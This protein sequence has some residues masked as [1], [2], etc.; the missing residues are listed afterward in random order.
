MVDVRDV[1]HAHVLSVTDRF[2]SR[3]NGRY[4]MSTKSLWFSE[5]VKILALNRI[6]LGVKRIKTRKL[7]VFSITIAGLLINPTLKDLLPFIN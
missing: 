7:G 6:N 3:R 2:L 4:M 1:A 5:I